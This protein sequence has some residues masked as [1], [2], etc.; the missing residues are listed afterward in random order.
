LH[1]A[2]NPTYLKGKGDGLVNTI[3]VVVFTTASLLLFRGHW[4]MAHG[5]K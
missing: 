4:K 2:D 5:S 3:S 1:G